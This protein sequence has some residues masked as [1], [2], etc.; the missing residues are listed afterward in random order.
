MLDTLLSDREVARITGRARSTLQKDRC[1]GRGIPYAALVRWCAGALPQIRRCRVAGRAADP[2]LN[3][4]AGE[5]RV[6]AAKIAAALGAAQRSGK[7]WRCPCPAHNSG[8][9]TLALRRRRRANCPLPCGLRA[10]PDDCRAVPAGLAC[11]H[12]GTP[13]RQRDPAE[14]ERRRAAD[15]RDRNRRIAEAL[16]FW[17]TKP[18]PAAQQHG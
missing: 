17:Q 4:R 6:T 3:L 5:A 10:Q 11:D 16:D 2:P 12:S 7:W 1:V 18:R 13:A 9:A 8:G 15:Q 14:I